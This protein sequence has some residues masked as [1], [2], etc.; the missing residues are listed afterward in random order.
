MLKLSEYYGSIKD[1]ISTTVSGGDYDHAP[2]SGA[3]YE[4]LLTKSDVEHE[5]VTLSGNEPGDFIRWNAENSTWEVASEPLSLAQI[6][7]VPSSSATIDAEGGIWY[8]SVDK[9]LMLCVSE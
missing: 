8:N 1:V 6:N 3:V 5:H 4:A 9:R 2:S 7:L